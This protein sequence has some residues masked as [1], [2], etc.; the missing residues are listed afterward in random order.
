[1]PF[2]LRELISQPFGPLPENSLDID[3]PSKGRLS[4]SLSSVRMFL[5]GRR[6][7]G[8]NETEFVD[9]FADNV[10]FIGRLL[11]EDL[12]WLST[13]GYEQLERELQ[14][15][16]VD[17]NKLRSYSGLTLRTLYGDIPGEGSRVTIWLLCNKKLTARFLTSNLDSTSL[18]FL[19]S[20]GRHYK[21]T[22]LDVHTYRRSHRYLERY[23]LLA[24]VD[25]FVKTRG[26][27]VADNTIDW[28]IKCI[29]Q[30]HDSSERRIL[31][32]S[33]DSETEVDV[34]MDDERNRGKLRRRRR[35]RH[36]SKA[37][38]RAV[39]A[40]DARWLLAE[41]LHRRAD[42]RSLSVRA[43]CRFCSEIAHMKR[44]NG[45]RPRVGNEVSD[46]ALFHFDINF[47]KYWT[48]GKTKEEWQRKLNHAL[49][50]EKE[51]KIKRKNSNTSKIGEPEQM[52]P[53]ILPVYHYDD[54]MS[55]ASTSAAS[56][57]EDEW[58]SDLRHSIGRSIPPWLATPPTLPPPGTFTWDCNCGAHIDVLEWCKGSKA[59]RANGATVQ[60]SDI[61]LHRLL[62]A[63]SDHYEDHL[64]QIGILEE[65]EELNT[66]R[67][68]A[69]AWVKV[70]EH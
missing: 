9:G 68:R 53:E 66:R 46:T 25:E 48:N 54:D 14:E 22:S 6:G 42:K 5:P 16:D 63:I 58:K 55:Q 2:S 38:A 13:R 7:T 52:L 59:R 20:E 24:M 34:E 41:H 23:R 10:Q 39:L 62:R 27:S 1:M 70:E 19:S 47:N 17:T 45:R 21:I 57:A 35:A 15:R 30:R 29:R 11:I 33:D 67:V 8:L 26:L 31:Y 40:K 44:W 36:L 50:Y 4:L 32:D 61:R 43:L 64:K 28:L 60:D 3:F 56:D 12:R 51:E 18:L 65:L 69:D 37:E 49:Q